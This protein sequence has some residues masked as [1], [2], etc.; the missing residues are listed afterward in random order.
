MV[1]SFHVGIV[2]LSSSG[3][4]LSSW[5]NQ[6][7]LC[8]VSLGSDLMSSQKSGRW[9]FSSTPVPGYFSFVGLNV[10]KSAQYGSSWQVNV[11]LSSVQ[12][13]ELSSRSS[14]WNQRVISRG[15]ERT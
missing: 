13:W 1:N 4:A 9:V 12:I 2:P 15:T 5:F 10:A 8:G 6:A 11:C 14:A 7:H 3:I